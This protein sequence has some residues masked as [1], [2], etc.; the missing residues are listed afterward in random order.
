M[1]LKLKNLIMLLL[2]GTAF[3][4]NETKSQSKSPV[5]IGFKGGANFSNLSLSKSNL[6]AKYSLGYHGGI[7]TRVDI[8]Q[9]YLQGEVLYSQK[10]SKIEN[11]SFGAQKAKWNS[12]EVPV[13][14]GYKLLN[15]EDLAFRIFGGGVYSYVL[16][17]KASILKQASQS[18]RRFDKSNIGYQAGAGV[19]IGRLTLDLKYEGALTN[20]SKEFKARPSSFQA[21]IGFM[22]F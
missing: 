5:H 1:E 7:F 3:I 18:F 13:L 14:V 2:I 11:G 8:S 6:D 10:K 17:D 16:N 21:S 15:S 9:F 19:D 22:I 4:T 12:I 20:M